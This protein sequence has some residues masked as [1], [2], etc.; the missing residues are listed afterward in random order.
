MRMALSGLALSLA[1]IP[2]TH[3]GQP[4]RLVRTIGSTQIALIDVFNAKD[5]AVY[6]AAVQE[7]CAEKKVCK[8]SFWSDESLLPENLPMTDAQ[9]R[10]VTATW[11]YDEASG[12]KQLST[13]FDPATDSGDCL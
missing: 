7:L 13:A 1:L 9:A 4:W 3:A 12:T 6:R 5:P 10:G 11:Y 2:A 8:V